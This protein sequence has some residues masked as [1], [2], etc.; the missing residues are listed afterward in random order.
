MARV[1]NT[2]I[3]F[4]D[5]TIWAFCFLPL[6]LL[7]FLYHNHP[8]Q[9]SRSIFFSIF[10]VLLKSSWSFWCNIY[11]YSFHNNITIQTLVPVLLG[12][13]MLLGGGHQVAPSNVSQF[14]LNPVSNLFLSPYSIFWILTSLTILLSIKNLKYIWI[15]FLTIWPQ[16][17]SSSV[18]IKLK[19]KSEIHLFLLP[20]PY[21]F[22]YEFLVGITASKSFIPQL[23]TWNQLV[24]NHFYISWKKKRKYSPHHTGAKRQGSS[25]AESSEPSLSPLRPFSLCW[26]E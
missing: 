14:W 15:I 12:S 6:F 7:P 3:W 2:N 10:L 20:E 21:H 22:T 9:D 5:Y 19:K 26:W 25:M 8:T 13:F 11:A 23:I 1:F 16:Q 18:Y 17:P 24:A 4:S